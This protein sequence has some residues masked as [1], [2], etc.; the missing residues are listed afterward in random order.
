MSVAPVVCSARARH[1]VSSRPCTPPTPA[2]ALPRPP[3]APRRRLDALRGG[4][5]SVSLYRDVSL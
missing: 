3:G 2:P 5:T 1:T 4:E